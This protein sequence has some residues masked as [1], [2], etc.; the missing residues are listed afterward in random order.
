[1]KTNLRQSRALAFLVVFVSAPWASS[2]G[3]GSKQMMLMEEDYAARLMSDPVVEV[4]IEY[5]APAVG[6]AAA[7]SLT[8]Q[9]STREGK[10]AEMK[11][12]HALWNDIVGVPDS[13]QTPVIEGGGQARKPA[14]IASSAHGPVAAKRFPQASWQM[15]AEK[16]REEFK[17]LALSGREPAAGSQGCTF[18]VKLR[19]V[20]TSGTVEE[21]LG[22]RGAGGW[23]RRVSEAVERWMSAAAPRT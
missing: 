1:M 10:V 2:C 5:A 3:V 22:C 14:S 23:T 21:L 19:M 18:P 17:D 15:N 12:Y 9:A 13:G 20:R 8:L 4:M 16:L 7:P 6:Y 11:L